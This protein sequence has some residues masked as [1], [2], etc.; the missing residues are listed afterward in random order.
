[1]SEAATLGTL[2]IEESSGWALA[3]N[4]THF[5]DM[6]SCGNNHPAVL[7]QMW[8]LLTWECGS[9]KRLGGQS[10]FNLPVGPPFPLA[11]VQPEKFV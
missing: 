11:S 4:S 3:S 9:L 5:I 2:H 1:M 7:S 8:A 6:A 10:V